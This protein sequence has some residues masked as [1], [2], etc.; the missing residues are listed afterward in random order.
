M[1]SLC[2]S[3][4]VTAQQGGY[5]VAL[6]L[7]CERM[8]TAAANALLK[9]L[10][11]PGAGTLLL[12]QSDRPGALLPTIVSRCQQLKIVRPSVQ[13][14]TQWLQQQYPQLDEDI[15]WCLPVAGG[16]LTLAEYIKEGYFAELK[17]LK[18][19]WQQSLSSGHLS[20]KL[21]NLNVEQL[22]DVLKLLYQVLQEEIQQT[23]L[24]PLI[25]LHLAQLAGQVMRDNQQLM[26]MSNVNYL[27]LCQSYVLEYK[28]MK[29]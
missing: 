18:T 27:A 17:K 10:E 22:F 1:R 23:Q 2:Q 13:L 16:A 9:T 12:L 3:L 4:N 8:N 24:D 14:I 29:K 25:K 28:R 26:Q 11:E 6:I 5:R 21:S 7:Q 19:A 15:S 20:Q